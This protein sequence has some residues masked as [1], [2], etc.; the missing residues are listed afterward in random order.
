M[1][2]LQLADKEYLQKNLYTHGSEEY[3]NLKND[4][5]QCC[6]KELSMMMEMSSGCVI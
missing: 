5:F 4:L 1:M 6:P 3:I 2:E